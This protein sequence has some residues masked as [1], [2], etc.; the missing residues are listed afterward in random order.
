MIHGKRSITADTA[1]RLAVYFGYSASFWMRLQINYDLQ[2]TEDSISSRIHRD[3][4][5]AA[6]D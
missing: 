4:K 2:V 3:V 5:Q 1:L 6:M